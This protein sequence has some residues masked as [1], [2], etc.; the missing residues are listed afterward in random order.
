MVSLR[1]Q[2]RF[3]S[4]NVK[5]L[6]K[7]TRLYNFTCKKL[8][9]LK[10]YPY[11]KTKSY[12]KL[13]R[14]ENARKLFLFKKIDTKAPLIIYTRHSAIMPVLLNRKLRVHKGRYFKEVILY[15]LQTLN[16]KIGQY[17]RSKRMGFFIHKN[18]KVA[19]KRAKMMA[20]RLNRNLPNKK[21]QVKK[22]KKI[23]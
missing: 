7:R 17:V 2:F 3:I 14:S 8:E 18:N 1:S 4:R 16:K 23:K 5:V 9:Y 13:L 10:K 6:Y 12:D 20:F 15:K 22:G 19:K 11:R 21:K